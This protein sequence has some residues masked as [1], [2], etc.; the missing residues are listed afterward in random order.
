QQ[1]YSPADTG[2][3]PAFLSSATS[4]RTSR[5]TVDRLSVTLSTSTITSTA[6]TSSRCLAIPG[7]IR[8]PPALPRLDWCGARGLTVITGRINLATQDN[9]ISHRARKGATFVAHRSR[10]GLRALR[11]EHVVLQVR[12]S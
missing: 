1:R 6:S 9:S 10:C 4:L 2:I 5:G 3:D 8:L 11:E 7:S 12:R